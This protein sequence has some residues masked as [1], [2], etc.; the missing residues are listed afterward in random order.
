[1]NIS[2]SGIELIKQFEGFRSKP[3]KDIAGVW[4]V[5]Y[6]HTAGVN[7]YTAPVTKREA[8][9]LLLRDLRWVEA[10]IK[11]Y[12]TGILTQ[13]RYDALA[14]FMFNIGTIAFKRSTL[15]KKVN[16]NQHDD[17]PVEF[18]KWIHAGGRQSQGLWN[19]RMAESEL[20]A[21]KD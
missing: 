13:N 2:Q 5:G 20:Y 21:R 19:R 4:T 10:A 12:V 8:E 6:G 16:A 1:M 9:A 14:S 15:L 3:Y 11:H 7:Q 18:M 17:V